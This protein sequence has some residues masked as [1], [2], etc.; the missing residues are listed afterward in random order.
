MF[1]EFARRL[2]SLPTLLSLSLSF[3]TSASLPLFAA[4]FSC[5]HFFCS[6][7][8]R[9][10]GDRRHSCHWNFK[11]IKTLPGAQRPN[12]LFPFAQLQPLR[13]EIELVVL[14]L[15]PL[16]SP[17][18]TLLTNPPSSLPAGRTK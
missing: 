2:P 9:G 17:T 5:C 16:H 11:A 18:V 13:I 6:F 10:N 4:S 12:G 1:D 8:A 3:L 7:W 14:P 15:T